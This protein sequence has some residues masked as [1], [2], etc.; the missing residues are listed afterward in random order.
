MITLK[1]S[2]LQLKGTNIQLLS[3][4][5]LHKKSDQDNPVFAPEDLPIEFDFDILTPKD[6]DKHT[7]FIVT[8]HIKI[9]KKRKR[10]TGHSIE[11]KSAFLFLIEDEVSEQ[12]ANNLK[13]FSALSIAISEIRTILNLATMKT[14]FGT[15][16]LPSIDLRNLFKVKQQTV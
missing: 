5:E 1:N 8:T 16:N 7:P 9:N 13:S 10:M 6:D 12:D 11:M 15:Y 14:A 3:V 2:A 4:R